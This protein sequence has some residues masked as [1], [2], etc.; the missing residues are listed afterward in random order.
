MVEGGGGGQGGGGGGAA[1]SGAEA[2][3][4]RMESRHR[5]IDGRGE[6]TRSRSGI[7]CR[8]AVVLLVCKSENAMLLVVMQR[9]NVA[10]QS[11]TM[12]Q[13]PLGES[14][15]VNGRQERDSSFGTKS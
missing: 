5:R 15:C 13:Q 3:S 12:Q 14:W 8:C 9:C 2:E 7:S 11:R 6:C 1:W 4:K 10:G